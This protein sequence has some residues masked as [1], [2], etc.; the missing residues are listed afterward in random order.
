VR[1]ALTA[2]F[3]AAALPACAAPQ[4]GRWGFDPANR[5]TAT[6]P[7][8]DFFRYAN[9]GW[10]DR[11]HIPDDKAGYSLR[12]EMSNLTEARLRGILEEAARA[13]EHRPATNEGKAGAFYR[14]FMDSARIDSLGAAP[15]APALD[16]VRGAKTRADLARLLGRT[17]SDFEG[18]L[19]SVF[20]DAD[21]DQPSRYAV[22]LGQAGLGLPDRDYYLETSFAEK[23]TKY[24][25]YVGTLLE[26]AG[27]PAA[28]QRAKEI[29]ALESAIARASWTRA[30]QRDPVTT[31]NPMT[32]AQ[33][34]KLAP[35]FAWR[36]FLR[37]AGVDGPG[38]VLVAEKSAFPR[39]AAL[40]AKTPLPTLRAWLAFT[41]ADNAAR[42]LSQ[43]F[44]SAHFDFRARTLSGQQAPAARW[45][46]GVHAVSGGDALSGDRADRFGNM[47]WA[48][49]EL[50]TARYF[51]PA[52]KA[53]IEDLVQHLKAA[54]RRRLENLDWMGPE[55][56]K[57]ALE[58]LDT[59]VIKV[60]YPDRARDHSKL[61]ILDD[62]LLGDVRRAAE[63][64]WAF[65]TD[66]LMGPV[67]KSDWIMTPQTNDAYNGSLRDIVFPAGIL[68]PPIFDPDADPAFNYGAAGGVIGHELTHGFDDQGRKFDATGKLSDW[69]TPAD[70]KAF[71]E[72]AARLGAQ[73]SKFEPLPGVHVNGVL[74]M[75]E[76]IADL[77]GLTLAL[78]AYREANGGQRTPVLDGMTGDQRVFLGWA[79]AWSGKSRD[80]A[81][82]RVV[83]SDPHS[84]RK[85]RVN[86]V[87]RNIDAWYDAFGVRAGQQLFVA[88]GDRVR[89][90]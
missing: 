15:L 85:F 56:R 31:H 72:R 14:A 70:A 87:V 75:G 9:G 20:I 7:G 29:V 16:A 41:I 3:L 34:E 33:L 26:L 24:E 42:F 84:P 52:S 25:A 6:A 67:D 82:R 79:Q 35:G 21:V 22:Y 19:W 50:F 63:L 80:D 5:D 45:K 60:G 83:V 49:G 36:P 17:N 40:W 32:I 48:V 43:P 73:Y 71:E 51:P 30:Q 37:E 89:I 81:I 46:R 69:W 38:R 12:L 86:G 11:T 88:P 23:K 18:S 74:T 13:A 2:V 78:E 44:V 77:G 28:R 53:A 62:D 65:Q 47:G 8:D 57:R 64:D 4:F 66:R 61:V 10:L 59:Y 1:A 76:N 90:W 27:W 55:T 58:K 39:L 68:Q 54:Y